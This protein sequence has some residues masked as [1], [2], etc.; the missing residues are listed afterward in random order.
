VFW[1]HDDTVEPENT[2]RYRIRLGVFN[3]VA[4]TNQLDQRDKSRAD[5]AIL[6][7]GFSDTTEP[8]DIMGRMYFF[9]NNVHEANKTVTVQVSR[10]ALG[11]WY[12]Q[13]FPVRQ[14][15]LVG[16]SRE[17]EPPEPD[18]RSTLGAAGV[19]NPATAVLGSVGRG[20]GPGVA[21]PGVSSRMST[22]GGSQDMSNIPEYIDYATGA[23]LVDA[24]RVSDWSPGRPMR[25]R[26]YYD[27]LYSFDGINIM[28][29]PVG[30]TNWP[31]DLVAKFGAIAKLEREPQEP[32]KAFGQGA[33]RRGVDDLGGYGD[34]MMYEDGYYDDM[35][36]MY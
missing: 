18:R 16:E 36:G 15:E 5:E 7:S 4:G 13:D 32:F 8:V 28:H 31:K 1:A 35:G 6:W 33:T 20:V 24:V 9:A 3:P 10:L 19:R 34:E 30:R 14:G 17:Y 23:V 27:M 26:L 11:H 21:G 29:M 22:F 2:Y 12:S 25:E